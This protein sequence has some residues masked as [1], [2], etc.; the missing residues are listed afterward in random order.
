MVALGIVIA[1][2]VAETC[3]HFFD[4]QVTYHDDFFDILIFDKEIGWMGK[5]NSTGYYD[6]FSLDGKFK[7]SSKYVYAEHFSTN[8]LGFKDREHSFDENYKIIVLGDSFTWG[9]G[10]NNSEVFTS[11]LENKYFKNFE[12]INLG[13]PGHGTTQ[14]YL[15]LKRF[16]PRFKPGIVLLMF[17]PNDYDD[18]LKSANGYYDRPLAILKDNGD[19]YI[20][21]SVSP[22]SL[23]R[24]IRLKLY[25]KTNFGRLMG[26]LIN[27][28]SIEQEEANYSN[29]YRRELN[30][31]LI[32]KINDFCKLN[33][34]QLII[35]TTNPNQTE[36]KEYCEN[37]NIIFID[38]FLNHPDGFPIFLIDGH[39]NKLGHEMV[40]QEIYR[41]LVDKKLHNQTNNSIYIRNSE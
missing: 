27:N 22:P 19:I 33:N 25:Y 23:L 10:V 7:N 35:A 11:I 26:N 5:P 12:I 13:M 16:G 3:L 9:M 31:A 4:P 17:C 36:L 38:L 20:S 8:S 32:N 21:N 1:L 6:R 37:K 28:Y 2:I 24:F 15:K 30:D 34:A 41:Q 29:G 39:W 18:N 40:A 14:N